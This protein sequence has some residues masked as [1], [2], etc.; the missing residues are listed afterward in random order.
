MGGGRLDGKIQAGSVILSVWKNKAMVDGR[1]I[2]LPNFK[3]SRIYSNKAGGKPGYTYN[4]R[5]ADLPRIVE[6]IGNYL[7]TPK[8]NK[9]D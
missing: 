1:E 6:V 2:W 8:V 5:E 7:S 9:G 3:L 4:F